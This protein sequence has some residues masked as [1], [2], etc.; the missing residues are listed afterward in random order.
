MQYWRHFNVAVTTD[1]INRVA[2]YPQAGA[3]KTIVRTLPNGFAIRPLHMFLGEPEQSCGIEDAG[4]RSPL[5]SKERVIVEFRDA[6]LTKNLRVQ[7]SQCAFL[8]TVAQGQ[9]EHAGVD[10]A[11]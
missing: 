11:L 2:I 5:C 9:L 10:R 6:V 8:S 4:C 7:R 3:D 1:A